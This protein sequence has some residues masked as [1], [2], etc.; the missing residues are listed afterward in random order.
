MTLKNI[1]SVTGF[2]GIILTK[3]V[4]ILPWPLFTISLFPFYLSCTLQ[5][6]FTFCNDT[7]ASPE[8]TSISTVP[9]LDTNYFCPLYCRSGLNYV[10]LSKEERSPER[11]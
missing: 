10:H 5:L 6:D 7:D 2:Y 3:V 8:L 11:I 9:C 1:I 4:N